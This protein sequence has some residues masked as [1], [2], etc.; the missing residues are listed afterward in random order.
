VNIADLEA[1]LPA[2]TVTLLTDVTDAA[3]VATA[4][5]EPVAARA[6]VHVLWTFR[7]DVPIDG[8]GGLGRT[9]H[10][11]RYRMSIF[12]L[13]ATQAQRRAWAEEVRSMHHRHL[14]TGVAGL[15]HAEVLGF[16]V[17]PQEEHG[18]TNPGRS[19]AAL[20]VADVLFVGDVEVS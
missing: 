11:L 3:Q 10:G 5:A 12:A 13:N 18:V 6:D 1:E 17:D 8:A 9:M 16:T 20:A 15:D 4:D 19:G 14:P 7:E 2:M